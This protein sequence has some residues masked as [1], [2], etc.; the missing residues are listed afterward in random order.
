[1]KKTLRDAC[2]VVSC[3][4]A[5]GIVC[6]PVSVALFDLMAASAVW[7]FDEDA[8]NVAVDT[9]RNGNDGKLDGQPKRV[10]GRFGRALE[11][12]GATSHVAVDEPV[13]LPDQWDPRTVCLWFKL[14]EP[15]WPAPGVELMG[16][17]QHIG[18]Q[19]FAVWFESPDGVG[20]DVAARCRWLFRWE[21]D[22]E[23]HHIALAFPELDLLDAKS[24]K[25]KLYFDGEPKEGDIFDSCVTRL[26]TAPKPVVIGARPPM[27]DLHFQGTLDEV[28]IFPWEL[29]PEDIADIA[30]VG[31]ETA[32]AV[33]PAGKLATS[34]GDLKFR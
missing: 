2:L 34:W 6:T 10:E 32:Q 26:N 31:L 8:G 3:L 13:D 18:G 30:T 11:F 28:A 22:T 27:I 16:W 9:T 29:D 14:A 5:T 1:M 4:V 23:W 15:A 17:G 12:D 24:D 33:S 20:A 19:R 21:A 7:L 25:I